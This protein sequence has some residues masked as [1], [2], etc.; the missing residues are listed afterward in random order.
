MIIQR[1]MLLKVLESVSPGLASKEIIEQS[2]C[3][4]FTEDGRV[5]TFNDEVCASRKSPLKVVGAVTAKPVLDLLSKLKEDEID[6]DVPKDKEGKS[7]GVM[8]IKGK[9]KRVKV[10][11]EAQVM[12]PVEGVEVPTEWQPL[13]PEFS[14]AVSIVHSCASKEASQFIMTCIHIHPKHL[15][16]YDRFQIGRYPVEMGIA[17]PTLVRAESLRKVLGYDMSEVALTGSWI[18]FRNA[19]G[20][21]LSIRRHLDQFP[22]LDKFLTKDG[23]TPIVLPKDLEETISRAEIFSSQNSIGNHLDVTI[24]GE[25]FKIDGI[26]SSGSYEEKKRVNYAGSRIR[27]LIAPTLL[28]ELSKKTSECGV[29][30]ERLFVDGGKFVYATSTLMEEDLIKKPE[31]GEDD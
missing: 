11:M 20:L 3:L 1:E 7:L 6:V 28:L 31:K 15:E 9:N 17:E 18:H 10:K 26:G 12:L 27:F 21:T 24:D 8:V 25:V 19:A 13:K 29:S 30:A 16:A 14:D 22:V 23:T 5:C 4:V 2:S